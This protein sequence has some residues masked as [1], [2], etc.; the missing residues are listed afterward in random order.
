PNS[1]EQQTQDAQKIV[2]HLLITSHYQTEPRKVLLENE[3]I[4]V[5]RAGS[6]D[7]LLDFDNLTSRH[8]AILKYDHEQYVIF[9]QRSAQGV[10]VNGQKLTAGV[11]WRLTDGDTITIGAYTLIFHINRETHTQDQISSAI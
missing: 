2:P 8:H 4:T 9:D 10:Y 7:I 1:D 6:S 5:G 11:G 3:L